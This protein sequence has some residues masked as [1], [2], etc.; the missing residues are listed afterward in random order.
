M[1]LYDGGRGGIS[2]TAEI[3]RLLQAP[4]ILVIDCK[5]MGASAAAIA[6]AFG[7]MPRMFILQALFSI[8]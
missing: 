7:N 4:V 8:A 1:G 5:S 6:L 3:A 2:S